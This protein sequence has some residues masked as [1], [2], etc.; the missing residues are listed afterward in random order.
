MPSVGMGSHTQT[1]AL[2][3]LCTLLVPRI[4]ADTQLI[5]H[6]PKTDELNS[7]QSSLQTVEK[8]SQS[9][10]SRNAH[11]LAPSAYT[12]YTTTITSRCNTFQADTELQ[13]VFGAF[14]IRVIRQTQSNSILVF[15]A[16]LYVRRLR[17]RNLNMSG[18]YQKPSRGLDFRLFALG[19]MLACKMQEDRWGADVIMAAVQSPSSQ[20]EHLSRSTWASILCVKNTAELALLERGF[21]VGLGY[22][23]F[24]GVEELT[25]FINEMRLVCD[26]SVA[27]HTRTIFELHMQDRIFSDVA[28]VIKR[29]T[30]D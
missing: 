15:V 17:L 13:S 27:R 9:V 16:L 8:Q 23:L 29:A 25:V 20:N 21:L 6:S 28:T 14:C 18:S 7:K 10:S 12:P 19:M 3:S 26:Q 4:W 22:E 30:C 24:V 11:R 5:K 2:A 1:N